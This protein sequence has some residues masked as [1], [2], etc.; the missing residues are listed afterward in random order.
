MP[1][2]NSLRCALAVVAVLHFLLSDSL[3]EASEWPRFRGPNG[4]GVSDAVTVPVEWSEDDY[5]WSA[6]LPGRGHSSPVVWGHRLFVTSADDKAAVRWLSCVDVRDGS[7]VWKHEFPFETH[8]KHKNNSYA[9]ST[10]AVDEDHVYVLWHSKVASPLVAFDHDGTKAWEIDLGPYLHGQGGATSPIV[11]EDLVVVAND[12]SAGSYLI[13]LDRKSG[14]ERWRIPREGKR[15]C[16]ATPCVFTA[17]GGEPELIFSHCYEGIIGVD[18]KTGRQNWHV[19]VFG[20]AS[21]RALGSPVVTGELVLATSGGVNGDKQLV[22]VRPGGAGSA[23]TVKEAYRV[24]RQTPHVPTPLIYKDRLFLWSDSGIASCLERDT[25][26]VIWQKRIGGNFFGS[27]VCID[28]KLYCIDVDGEVVVIAASDEYELLARNPLGET[29][30]ATPAVSGGTLFL[31][32][33]SRV[34]SVGGPS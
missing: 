7:E 10:P 19:D 30:R 20:R 6:Q 17:P 13:A 31:R 14:K 24:T 16:Y 18:P 33:E 28:G 34:I 3:S 22:A 23:A 5:N 1:L 29:S 32:T 2:R 26:K 27:P 21:Q 11:Y 25:G 12:H 4:S 15:A 8:K 9:S